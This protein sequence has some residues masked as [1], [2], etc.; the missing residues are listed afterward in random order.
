MYALGILPASAM[1]NRRKKYLI[2]PRVQILSALIVVGSVGLS[3]LVLTLLAQSSVATLATDHPRITREYVADLQSELLRDLALAAGVLG[4]LA[5]AIGVLMTFRIVGPIYRLETYLLQL[6][7]DEDI[8]PCRLRAKDELHDF[9]DVLNEA[10]ERLR[11][12]AREMPESPA[13]QPAP[14]SLVEQERKRVSA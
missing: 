14:Q 6:M 7:R 1:T 3:L 10:V 12:S 9:C 11:N 5:F 2:R 4:P 8:G 13:E